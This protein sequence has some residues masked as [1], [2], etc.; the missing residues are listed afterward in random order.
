MLRP[1][2]IRTAAIARKEIMHIQR[3][4]Q[5]LMFALACPWCS[6][7]CSATASPSTSIA[8]PWWWSIRTSRRA[9][10]LWWT[11]S[12]PLTPFAS[13]PARRPQPVET[14]L[15]SIVAKAAIIIPRA[16]VTRFGG[17]GGAGAA[18]VGWCGQ[19]RS[20]HRPRLRQGRLI[21]RVQRAAGLGPGQARRALDARVR[22]FFNPQLKSSVF[23]VPGLM[24]VIL[25]MIA[26]MLTALTVAREYERGS[27][28]QLFA[29]PIGRLE[30]ILASSCPTS[31]SAVAG[32]ARADAGGHPLRRAGAR[33]PGAPVRPLGLVFAAMLMQGLLISVLTRH[34]QVASM[35]AMISTFLPALLL[36]GFLFP[37]ANMPWILRALATVFPA[38]YFVRALRA[39]LLRGNGLDVI[40]PDMLALTGFFLALLALATA[41]FKR[42]WREVIRC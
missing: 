6:S 26:V 41:R 8:S 32:P 11:D 15:R 10:G 28:E 23:L 5:V 14:L 2:L 22:V 42:T 30:V 29:T 34:Q 33:Q 1:L 31:P 7:C 12:P 39:I 27:M 19:H 17:A 25:V 21:V 18:P 3:D 35:V 36:S 38:Q 13:C 37:L 16:S 24:V 4:P 9:P 20:L 40:W